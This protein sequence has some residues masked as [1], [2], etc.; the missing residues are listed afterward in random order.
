M[1][2]ENTSQLK[3]YIQSLVSRNID[4]SHFINGNLKRLQEFFK[5]VAENETVLY[6]EWP[7]LKP[8]EREG[9]IDHK[10]VTGLAILR[11]VAQDDYDAQDLAISQCMEIAE[12]IMLRMRRD[13]HIEQHFYSINDIPSIDPVSLYMVDNCFG[14]RFEIQPGD[15]ISTAVNTSKWTDL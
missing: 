5:D 4:I 1:A 15:W 12:Q 14:C 11:S 10:L 8:R 3:T 7:S 9:S 13:Q 6:M 2:L